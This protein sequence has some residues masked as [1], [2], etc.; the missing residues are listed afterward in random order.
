MIIFN[1]G[2]LFF[3]AYLFDM[4]FMTVDSQEKVGNETCKHLH[5]KTVWCPSNEMIYLEMLFPPPEEGYYVPAEFV[6]KSNWGIHLAPVSNCYHVEYK[7]NLTND[8]FIL[9]TDR[10]FH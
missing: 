10:K 3:D 8:A 7:D 6:D 2:R 1:G 4:G 9:K 5:H